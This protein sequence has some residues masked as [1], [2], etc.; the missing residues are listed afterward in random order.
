MANPSMFPYLRVP[1]TPGVATH[2]LVG[3]LP[4]WYWTLELPPE[5]SKFFC[6]ESVVPKDLEHLLKKEFGIEG[7]F[8]ESVRGFGF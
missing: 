7:S 4:D 2:C 1:T 6:L 5:L 8:G 3:D